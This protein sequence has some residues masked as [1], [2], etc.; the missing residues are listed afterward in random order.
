MRDATPVKEKS[1][2]ETQQEVTSIRDQ[3]VTLTD[4]VGTLNKLLTQMQADKAKEKKEEKDAKAKEK[5]EEDA[6]RKALLMMIQETKGAGQGLVTV[7]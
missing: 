4:Q 7:G 1:L 6:M 3:V 2:T 5:K